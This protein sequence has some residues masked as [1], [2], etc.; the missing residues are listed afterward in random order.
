M[1]QNTDESLRTVEREMSTSTAECV[2][3]W[4][5]LCVGCPS[6]FYCVIKVGGGLISVPGLWSSCSSVHVSS[7][8]ASSSHGSCCSGSG[9]GE[10]GSCGSKG[11]EGEVIA[12]IRSRSGIRERT[13]RPTPAIMSPCD[14]T[15]KGQQ[16]HKV[17]LRLFSLYVC[18]CVCCA[19][20]HTLTFVSSWPC[21]FVCVFVAHRA[22]Y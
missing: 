14:L 3:K 2:W 22:P 20:V 13:L 15:S 16:Q 6:G 21:V 4:S 11:T 10:T 18:L 12:W 5:A 1:E 17:S 8:D 9:S 19:C 7:G